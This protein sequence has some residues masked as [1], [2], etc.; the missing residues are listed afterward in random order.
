MNA[1][2]SL[3]TCESA[4]FRYRD[5][6]I[7]KG[8]SIA[9]SEGAFLGVIGPNGVGKSTLIRVLTG[10]L[11]PERG[12]VLLYGKPLTAF[13]RRAIARKLA[14]VSQT[15]TSDFG[16][17]VWEEVMLGRSP[18]HG[19]IHYENREDR[20]IVE[21]ALEKTQVAHL[22]ARRLDTLSGGEMQRVRIARG[23]AQQPAIV[24]LDEPT[25]HLDLYSQLTLMELLK[26]INKQ[27]IAVFLVSHDIN[28]VAQCCA[29]VHL[30][31]DG[32]ILAH[33]APHEVITPDLVATCFRIRANVSVDPETSVPRINPLGIL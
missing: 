30:M 21:M 8:V 15:E 24:F 12:R 10:T 3:L 5:A 22:A 25:T 28:F 11:L 33:G 17:T 20:A 13:T 31:H 9:V 4:S 18:H 27:G 16:F 14:V 29:D 6:P 1:A 7:L 2:R 32:A 19:G 23:I 26:E